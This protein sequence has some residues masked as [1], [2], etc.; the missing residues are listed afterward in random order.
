MTSVVPLGKGDSERSEQGVHRARGFVKDGPDGFHGT[1]LYQSEPI[2]GYFDQVGRAV[3]Q[4]RLRA[5]THAA[6]SPRRALCILV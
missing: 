5:F 2:Q 6:R 3:D 4:L 1:R